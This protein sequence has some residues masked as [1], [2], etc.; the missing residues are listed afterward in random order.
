MAAPKQAS[1][2][3]AVKAQSPQTMMMPPTQRHTPVDPPPPV[4]TQ[5]PVYMDPPP[6]PPPPPPPVQRVAPVSV[7]ESQPLR[8]A[9]SAYD[10]PV[11]PPKQGM[12]AW[13]VVL[14][15]AAVLIGAG[16]VGI[17]MLRPSSGTP[18]A[19]VAKKAAPAGDKAANPFAK[20]LE[21]LGIRLSENAQK[22][23]QIRMIVVN[24]S[25]ADLPDLKL[26]VVLRTEGSAEPLASFP[27]TIAALG[28]LESREIKTE[29]P[30]KLRAYEF[31]DWQFL[32][33]EFEV[34]GQ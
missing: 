25:T 10:I 12:P 33:A 24:H 2:A 20:H 7:A 34:V 6:P 26:N 3:A 28:A 23:L 18:A 27:V 22:K 9:R 17:T 1:P 4:V 29:T 32:K 14:I 19:S 13:A 8:P 30:T 11:P 16:W 5:F 31:P 21:L 15:V